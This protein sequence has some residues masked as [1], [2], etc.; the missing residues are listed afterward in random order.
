MTAQNHPTN[1][2]TPRLHWLN[3]VVATVEASSNLVGNV[4]RN[5]E[6]LVTDVVSDTSEVAGDVVTMSTMLAETVGDIRQ[7]IRSVPRI[8]RIARDVLWVVGAYKLHLNP[9]GRK[10]E[11][12]EATHQACAERLYRMCV[13]LR[14]GVLKIGQV[15]SSRVDLLPQAY[16][17]KLSTLQDQVPPVPTALI[18]ERIEQEL[19]GAIGDL[20]AEFDEQ[21]LAA[22]S[23]AQVHAA[24]LHDGRE[25]VV[26]VQVPGIELLIEADMVALRFFSNTFDSRIPQLDLLTIAEEVERSIRLE[27]D[28]EKEAV[29]AERFGSMFRDDPAIIVP[30]VH[31]DLSTQRVITLERIVGDRL[32]PFLEGC[33]NR[34]SKG[35]QDRDK[36]FTT[37]ISNTCSQVLDHGLFQADPHPGNYLVCSGARLCL[38]DFGSVMTFEPAVRNAYM[39]LAGTILSGDVDKMVSCLAAAGFSG[40]TGHELELRE[41]ASLFV[42]LFHQDM[43]SDFSEWNLEE[44]L[45]KAW[46]LARE[47]PIAKIP[48]NFVLLG[49]VLGTISGLF[50]RFK[51]TINL[52]AV[53]MPY[54][55]GA[56]GPVEVS[57]EAALG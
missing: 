8:T 31:T 6:R 41:F 4:L 2:E 17:D 7:T 25:V 32:V 30:K 39:E 22:A 43:I 45:D 18:V 50:L 21:P 52:A 11:S 48:H 20:F 1:H 51:P 44:Q 15:A 35:L 16:I 19:G 26:K 55:A 37:L 53:A 38:L 3:R 34:G 23:L 33:E 47:N 57:S 13:D 40:Q 46:R 49:R 27:L 54:L 5:C 28:Y 29:S 42:E 24:R 14:G 36:L 12:L 9:N 56:F 10:P